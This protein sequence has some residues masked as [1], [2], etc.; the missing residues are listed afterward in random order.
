MILM[1][2]PLS[3]ICCGLPIGIYKQNFLSQDAETVFLGL[4]SDFPSNLKRIVRG[5]MLKQGLSIDTTF[6]PPQFLLDS[7]IKNV[8]SPFLY[9]FFFFFFFFLKI[10]PG[11]RGFFCFK[12]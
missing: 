12:I 2:F 9:F 3:A 7:T 5:S 8:F 1:G 11:R 10:R 6:N 4:K